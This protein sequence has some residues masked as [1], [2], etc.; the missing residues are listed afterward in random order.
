MVGRALGLFGFLILLPALS[1]W[2][3]H[4][5]THDESVLMGVPGMIA[6][7]VGWITLWAGIAQITG[8]SLRDFARGEG[9]WH[10]R[11]TPAASTKLT[12][13]DSTD[14]EEPH[15]DTYLRQQQELL[16]TLDLRLHELRLKQ[17]KLGSVFSAGEAVELR[18]AEAE[19]RR[20]RENILAYKKQSSNP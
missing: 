17:A 19:S 1:F 5:I 18:E 15:M 12:S 20:L 16:D 8:Y 7:I 9:R 14:A 4:L 2:T 13:Q 3:Y 11:S 6:V 10:P